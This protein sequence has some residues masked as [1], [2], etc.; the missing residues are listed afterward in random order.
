MMCKIGM[1]IQSTEERKPRWEYLQE[2][3]ESK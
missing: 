2:A 3:P 1:R